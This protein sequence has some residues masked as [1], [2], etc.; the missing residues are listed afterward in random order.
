MSL[1][2]VIFDFDGVLADTEPL[3]LR[4]FQAALA[5]GPMTLT[6]EAYWER[7]LGLDDSG[8]FAAVARDQHAPLDAD[9]AARL[10]AAKGDH[11]ATLVAKVEVVY[12]AARR[13][14]EGLA[15]DGIALAVASGALHD[16][17]DA[18]L[19]RAGLRQH[20]AA[21]VAADDVAASKPAP[22]TYARAVERLCATLGRVPAA[23][24]FVAVEDSRWGIESATAA[25]LP[26]VGVT[27]SYGAEALPGAVAVISSLDELH[28]GMLD[29]IATTL[30]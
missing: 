21:V 5:G 28:R 17:I 24:G 9:A 6:D 15:A 2:G 8:L 23:A 26:C 27:T 25:G 12:P 19:V 11:F 29:A 30:R 14:V 22:D 3:H 18:I 7:Y 10:A 13:C 20:F 16:E 4:A 1:L